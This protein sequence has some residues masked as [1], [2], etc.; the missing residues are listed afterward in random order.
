M[1][2]GALFAGSAQNARA[3]RAARRRRRRNGRSPV[4]SASTTAA[5]CSAGLKVY[6][7]VCSACHALTLYRVP[8]SRRSRRS[9]LFDGD[10]AV[11]WRPNTRSSDGPV[12]IRATCSTGPAGRR[13]ISPRR[14][15]TSRPP[16]A[17]NVQAP[18]P[19]ILSAHGEARPYERGFPGFIF[20]S[21]ASS[22]SRARTMS[23]PSCR[24][25]RTSR[26]PVSP[27]P[28][29]PTTT[30]ISPATPSRCRSR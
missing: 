25:S 23:A 1:V 11:V 10:V 24:V 6:K 13:I 21:S 2:A 18:P 7:E 27:F 22:R 12:W 14:F 4:R 15:P 30:S 3:A 29:A 17:A 28:R 8:Q 26:R 16:A 20:A 19:P 5:R 9:R